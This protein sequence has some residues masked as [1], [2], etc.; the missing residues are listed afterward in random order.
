MPVDAGPEPMTAAA[1]GEAG[2]CDAGSFRTARGFR[3]ACRDQPV[4][5]G[6]SRIAS[7][8]R[9]APHPAPNAGAGSRPIHGTDRCPA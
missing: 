1:T 2:V 5:A 3:R 6:A 4:G 8:R 9:S 7:S